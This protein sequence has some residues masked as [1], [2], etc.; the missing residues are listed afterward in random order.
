V[1]SVWQ[2]LSDRIGANRILRVM[3]VYPP[4]LGAGI[5]VTRVAEDLTCIEV[6]MPLNRL[7]QNFVGTQFG[8][9]LYAMCDPFFMMIAYLKLGPDYVVWDKSASIRFV[10]PGRGRV[11]ARFEIPPERL[12]AIR[13]DADANGRTTPEF[14]AE[15]LDDAGEVVARVHKVL[16]VRRKSGGGGAAAT[17]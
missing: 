15:V 10:R 1:I 14:D 9:S 3:S 13:A 12:Q 4:F 2:W 11:R 17:G 5:R 7:N 16:S 8:G 6:E